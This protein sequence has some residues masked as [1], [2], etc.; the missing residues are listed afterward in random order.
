MKFAV[1]A[2]TAILV[3]GCSE[4]NENATKTSSNGRSLSFTLTSRTTVKTTSQ[5]KSLKLW[6]PLVQ[7]TKFQEVSGLKIET[8]VNYKITTDPLF[9]NKIVFVEAPADKPVEVTWS[10]KITRREATAWEESISPE[11]LERMK[12]EDRLGPIND[13]IIAI[14]EKISADNE[15]DANYVRGVYDYIV[16]NWKYDKET[17][18]WGRGDVMRAIQVCR[19]NCTDFHA[20]FNALCRAKGIPSMFYYGIAI[21]WGRETGNG[22]KHCWASAY[23]GGKFLPVDLSESWKNQSMREYYFGHLD[24]R[25][26]E[27][28]RG[29]DITLEPK[30]EGDALNFFIDAYAEVDGKQIDGVETV[31]TFST[32]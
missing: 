26:V 5:G 30:Q 32:K 20:P 19:G 23:V 18:G 9:G 6:V 10:A 25:R 15:G 29:R 3:I 1:I 11:L 8:S 28:S 21:P 22:V 14:A 2:A 17:A 31:Y 27:I 7:S 16:K 12:K 4:T 13:K 24:E